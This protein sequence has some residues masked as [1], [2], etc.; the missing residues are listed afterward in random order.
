MSVAGKVLNLSE[1][2]DLHASSAELRTTCVL[3]VNLLELITVDSIRFFFIT[4][5]RF[6]M[7]DVDF[8]LRSF[9][10]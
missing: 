4:A 6:F 1:T 5:D 8:L 10:D 7:Q 9:R 2:G 3:D